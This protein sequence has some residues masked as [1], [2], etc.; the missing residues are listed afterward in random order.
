LKFLG[1]DEGG[2]DKV[3]TRAVDF[4]VERCVSH[5]MVKTDEP[6]CQG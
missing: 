5:F 3:S 6:F 2:K 1:E 4:L